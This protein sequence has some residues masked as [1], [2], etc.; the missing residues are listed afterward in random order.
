MGG[1]IMTNLHGIEFIDTTGV[2]NKFK[3]ADGKPRVSCTEYLYD[4]AEGNITGH[5]PFSKM[6]YNGD[7]DSGAT[8]EDLWAF[9]GTYV[10]PT[11]EQGMEVRSSSDNDGKT[12]AP[13]STGVRTVTIYYLNLAGAEKTETVT[14]DGTTNVNTVATD[15]FR[16]QNFRVTT[17]GSGGVAA[18]DID[19]RNKT[20]HATVY[21]RISTGMTRARNSIYRVPAGKTLYITSI[22][23]SAIGASAGKD[24]IFTLL[25]KYDDK[26]ASVIDFFMPHIEIGVVDGSFIREFELPLKIIA[27]VDIKVRGVAGNDNSKCSCALR[28]WLE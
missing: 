28:G 16:V 9:G 27:L 7:I 8:G 17:C 21:S 10:Y 2:S 26:S 25:A 24:V 1:D 15:I 14:L 4:I 18:G 3:N 13:T 12:G 11:A 6:G 19:I 20:D 22:A 5:T 23:V